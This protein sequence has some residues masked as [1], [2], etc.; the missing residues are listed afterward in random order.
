MFLMEMVSMS[1]YENVLNEY[2]IKTYEKCIY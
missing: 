1:D 2:K